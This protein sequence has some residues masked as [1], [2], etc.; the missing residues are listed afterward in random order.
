[1][2]SEKEKEHSCGQ[3]AANM[4]DYGSKIRPVD[5][6]GSSMQTAT[7]TTESGSMIWLTVE[8]VMNT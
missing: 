4:K 8:V 2:V 1:M 3:M 7:C 5:M 6:E